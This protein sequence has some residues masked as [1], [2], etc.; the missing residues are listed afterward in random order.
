MKKIIVVLFVVACLIFYAFKT[1]NSDPAISFLNS[2][3]KEQRGKVQMAFDDNSRMSWHFLPGVMW[4]RKGIQLQE[5]NDP[6]KK[7]LFK[8]LRVYLSESGFVK[9]MK[10]IELENVLA[11]MSGNS[12]FRDAEKY[13]VA[14]YGRPGQDSLWAWSFEG[15]HIS[16]NFSVLDDKISVVPRFLGASPATIK[17]GPRKGERTLDKEEDY[18]FELINSL[19][20]EQLKLTV[21]RKTAYSEIVTSNAT[22]VGLLD[23]V[24]IK[25]D[26]LN[27]DQQAVLLKLL[28]EYISVMPEDLAA[29][30][31]QNLRSEDFESIRFGWAGSTLPG[32]PHYYRIQG[33]SFLVEFDNVQEGANHIHTVWRDFKGDFGRDLIR[34][35][36]K[37]S[38]HKN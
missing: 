35:H 34:E 19:T 30:R 31:M 8:L 33:N 15:H 13:Y 5:L 3:N 24:G 11:S 16:L 18:G 21:F 20:D 14:F 12:S 29:K 36:Y 38:H 25:M 1:F 28:M 23:P 9:T 6:Q 37:H 26:E 7:L 22:E 10:I 27:R 2:L 4:P 32:E 17:E